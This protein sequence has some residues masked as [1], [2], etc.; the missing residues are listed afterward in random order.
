MVQVIW[1]LSSIRK[2]SISGSKRYC[3][4]FKIPQDKGKYGFSQ[5]CQI[6]YV[7]TL[8]WRYFSH[9]PAEVAPIMQQQT[10]STDEEED[11]KFLLL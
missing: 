10:D 8:L 5:S 3:R 1:D 2:F 11:Q 9:S 6:H 7:F 4:H